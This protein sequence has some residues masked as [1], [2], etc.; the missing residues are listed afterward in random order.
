MLISAIINT[1]ASI[2]APGNFAFVWAEI[3]SLS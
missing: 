1:A 2:Y 3:F